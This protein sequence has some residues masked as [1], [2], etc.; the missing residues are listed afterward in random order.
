MSPKGSVEATFHTQLPQD[1]VAY[2]TWI[3][4]KG[5]AGGEYTLKFA[6]HAYGSSAYSPPAERKIQIRSFRS[7]KL[8]VR[9][10]FLGRGYSPGDEVRAK[11]SWEDS[12]SDNPC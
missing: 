7:P 1:S 5:Q 11:V 6:P 2:A 9:V 3:V 10:E 8:N 12:G 4:P